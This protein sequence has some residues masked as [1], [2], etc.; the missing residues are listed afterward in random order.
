MLGRVICAEHKIRLTTFDAESIKQNI[1]LFINGRLVAD[2]A[3]FGTVFGDMCRV[4]RVKN[5]YQD[6]GRNVEDAERCLYRL[7]K[8]EVVE[9]VGIAEGLNSFLVAAAK[10][11]LVH[12]GGR[13]FCKVYRRCADY[14]LYCRAA[15]LGR[16][17][18]CRLLDVVHAVSVCHISSSLKFGLYDPVQTVNVPALA[19]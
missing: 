6:D 2:G 4:R 1:L 15:F 17:H 10:N 16:G 13:V 7:A 9:V 14:D 11:G 5:V 8:R 19:V 12:C 18:A 3:A